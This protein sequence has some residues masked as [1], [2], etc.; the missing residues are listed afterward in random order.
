MILVNQKDPGL[1]FRFGLSRW[2]RL[3]SIARALSWI[4]QGT[5][6][7]AAWSGEPPWNRLNFT[8]PVGQTV[9]EQDAAALAEKIERLMEIIEETKPGTE[10]AFTYRDWYPERQ[11][12]WSFYYHIG[13]REEDNQFLYSNWS[14]RKLTELVF[15]CRQGAFLIHQD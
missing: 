3:L 5:T 6:A 15:F 12:L 7:P 13:L 2:V 4:P 14:R 10:S 9:E 1:T 11:R 8:I